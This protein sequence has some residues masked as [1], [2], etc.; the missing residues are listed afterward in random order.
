MQIKKYQLPKEETLKWL[1]KLR[2]MP[3]TE[4]HMGELKSIKRPDCYCSIGVYCVANQIDISPD[5]LS[6]VVNG[7]I[8]NYYTGGPFEERFVKQ[9]VSMNDKK[10]LS[11]NEIADWVE[12]NVELI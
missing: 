6:M 7:E 2:S 11:F 1:K 3:E 5:G 12:Q 9:I 8:L 10:E 4:H